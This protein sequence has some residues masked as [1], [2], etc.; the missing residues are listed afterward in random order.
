MT[1][2][3]HSFVTRAVSTVAI[4][5][6]FKYNAVLVP[7]RKNDYILF[8]LQFLL[9]CIA[10]SFMLKKNCSKTLSRVCPSGWRFNY[11]CVSS[12]SSLSVEESSSRIMSFEILIKMPSPR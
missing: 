3:F 1:F 4:I 2:K 12:A 5:K 8:V 11:R 7:S 10:I 9:N 6:G